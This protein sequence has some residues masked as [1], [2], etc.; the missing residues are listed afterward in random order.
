MDGGSSLPAASQ[1]FEGSLSQSRTPAP[2]AEHVPLEHVC[3]VEHVAVE[4]LVPQLVSR[5]VRF[6]QPFRPEPSHSS[7]PA[8]HPTQTPLLQVSVFVAQGAAVPHCPL[9]EQVC[10]AVPEHC[11]V[12]GTHTPVQAPETHA[13]PTHGEGVPHSPLDE[14]VSI[15]LFEHCLA[16]G[17]HTPVHAPLT[18]A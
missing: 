1:P 17:V 15:P 7:V 18:Q 9:E 16:P 11:F 2:Q 8:P 13:D 3:A 10:T 12:P 5:L 6:S 4:Q 14:H